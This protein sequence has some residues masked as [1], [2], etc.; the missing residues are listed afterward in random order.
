[1]LVIERMCDDMDLL[2]GAHGG[3]RGLDLTWQ[4]HDDFF[5]I[6]LG[7]NLPTYLWKLQT[8]LSINIA[9]CSLSSTSI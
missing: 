8:H 7:T 2:L 4:I 1:M 6:N 5:N 3:G 9:A